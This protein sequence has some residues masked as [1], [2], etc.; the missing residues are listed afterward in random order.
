MQLKFPNKLTENSEGKGEK[1][2]GKRER[3]REKA[4]EFKLQAEHR[5]W[6]IH[7]NSSQRSIKR[8]H[9]HTKKNYIELL[10]F[11]NFNMNKL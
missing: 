9:T 1:G 4:L 10:K 3:E 7:I 8:T 11:G 6:F 2:K 5:W